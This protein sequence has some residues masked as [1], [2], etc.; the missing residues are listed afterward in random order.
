MDPLE[1]RLKNLKEPRL[2]TVLETAAE[3]FGWDK[4]KAAAGHGFGIAGGTEKGG[5][6][7]TC[8][9]IEIPAQGHPIRV[10]RVVQAFECG[11]IVNPDELKNQV[12][13]AIMMGLGGALFEAID[14]DRGRILNA[15]FSRYRVPRFRD[16]PEIDVVLVN[17]KDLPSAGAG[18]SPIMEIAPAIGNAYFA[19]TRKR[20]RSLPLKPETA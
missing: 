19:A 2:R 12:Q 15:R 14:F 4:R 18:E 5:Y 7:G 6:V 1:F 11:A 9:E 13:G 17:R 3:R 10:V 20:L 8:A 16:L